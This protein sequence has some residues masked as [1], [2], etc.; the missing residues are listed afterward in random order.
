MR[1]IIQYRLG[2][3]RKLQDILSIVLNGKLGIVGEST[4]GLSICHL[5]GVVATS[6]LDEVVEHA[7]LHPVGFEKS[8]YEDS[9]LV[10]IIGILSIQQTAQLL[11]RSSAQSRKSA[12]SLAPNLLR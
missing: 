4:A 6:G 1:E 3:T 12:M 11:S 8:L 2:P 9:T 5:D 10:K 7:F